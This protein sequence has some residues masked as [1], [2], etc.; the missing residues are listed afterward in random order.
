MAQAASLDLVGILRAGTEKGI[1]IRWTGLP[2]AVMAAGCFTVKV[3]FHAAE[4][5]SGSSR[6]RHR[7]RSFARSRR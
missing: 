6:R 5:I 2:E 4:T 1:D 7:D 3:V